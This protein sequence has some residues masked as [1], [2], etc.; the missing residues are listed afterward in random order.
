MRYQVLV[1]SDG[2]RFDV[3]RAEPPREGEAIAPG[4]MVY[5]VLR[6]L[7]GDEEYD[8]IIEAEWQAGPAQGWRK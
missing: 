3:E 5:R 4:S 6:L 7:P 8:G 2:S 1:V